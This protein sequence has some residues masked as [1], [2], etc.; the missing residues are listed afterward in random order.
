MVGTDSRDQW[1]SKIDLSRVLALFRDN[2]ANA[3]LYKVLPRNAN[4]KNQVYLASD[5]SQL[6][7]LPSGEVT[8]HDSTSS[9]KGGVEAVFRAALEFYWLAQ[10]G[11]A[12]RAPDAKLIFYPQYP[13][14]RFSGFL[15]GCKEAPSSLW[16]KDK[17]GE[18]PDRLLL[19]GT[20]TDNRVLGLTLPSE[21][22]AAKAIF[23]INRLTDVLLHPLS[24]SEQ[25]EEEGLQEL[26]Q[27]L[28]AIHQRGWVPSTRLDSKGKLV[29]CNASNCNGNTLESLLGIRSNGLA[30]PDFRGWEVKAR[31]VRDISAPNASIVTLFTPEPTAGFYAEWPLHDFLQHYG[32]PDTQGRPDRLNFG[33]IYRSGGAPHERTRLRLA[34]Q[35]FSPDTGHYS[36]NGAITMMDT[37]GNEVMS[38]SFAK[39]LD[40]WKVKHAQ[41]AYVP[42]QM[43]QEPERQYWYARKI[44]IG[45]GAEFGLVLKA[46]HEGKLY[47]DPG[48]K[49]EGVSSAAPQSKKRSQF[50]INSRDLPALYK[51]STVIDVCSHD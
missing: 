8:K 45:E 34:L 5:F 13:E 51:K 2:G 6:A 50:R 29:P 18:E 20:G 32:Y 44:L 19:L 12:C 4:S 16:V 39:L 42:V 47:Y 31:T 15:R 38:W 40:H 26:K 21:S 33:G 11:Q 24:M 49:L 10:N 46:V 43:R 1:L 27:Q 41:A 35:G 36:P 37:D 7:R 17:R 14:V 23:A 25:R 22:P 28:C 48:I 9:K 30:L 3:L